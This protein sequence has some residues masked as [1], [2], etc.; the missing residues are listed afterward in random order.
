M[1]LQYQI[2]MHLH[3]F[4][5]GLRTQAY[6]KSQY[7]SDWTQLPNG[8]IDTADDEE[9][10]NTTITELYPYTNYI[11]KIRMQSNNSNITDEKYWSEYAVNTSKTLAD[12]PDA[13]PQTAR[14]GFEVVTHHLQK[15]NV[16]VYWR[17]IEEY[18]KNGPNFK[19][20]ITEVLQN[21]APR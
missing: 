12:V 4:P 14:G 10:V 2:D 8:Y 17:Q 13:P 21:G 19:Y 11:F 5:P 9:I 20:A 1:D 15:R 18:F 16:F 7:S 3:Y 6:Y